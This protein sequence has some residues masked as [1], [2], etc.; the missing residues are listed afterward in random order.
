MAVCQEITKQ[1]YLEAGKP[2]LY[3]DDSNF[4]ITS[5]QFS[6]TAAVDGIMLRKKPAANFFM[7]AYFAEPLL[8]TETGASTGAIH[9]AGPDSDHQLRIHDTN[10]DYT[11]TV[12]AH[13][14]SSA[15]L[16]YQPVI[17]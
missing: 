1:A 10:C 13:Y 17:V 12:D 15:S 9:T 7:G 8:L 14:A 11:V 2:D 5:D 6:Y 4:F 16:H 3:K